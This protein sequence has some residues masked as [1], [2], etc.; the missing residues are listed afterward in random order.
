MKLKKTSAIKIKFISFIFVV[1]IFGCASPPSIN[2]KDINIGMNINEANEI[3]KKKSQSITI[4]VRT[5]ENNPATAYVYMKDGITWIKGNPALGGITR[6]SVYMVSLISEDGIVI[7]KNEREYLKENFT[8][9][10]GSD[11][12]NFAG[13]LVAKDFCSKDESVEKIAEYNFIISKMNE[14]LTYDA[15]VLNGVYRKLV[16]TVSQDTAA[17]ADICTPFKIKMEEMKLQYK[18]SIEKANRPVGDHI[19]INQESTPSY[20]PNNT[21]CTTYGNTTNCTKY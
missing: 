15:M 16:P 18:A 19:I 6:E 20:E 17:S 11:Y 8:F 7:E 10:N 14:N 9:R 1:F 3:L 5:K 13:L 2:T 21:R 12:E 4:D